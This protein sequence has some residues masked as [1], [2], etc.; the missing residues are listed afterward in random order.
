MPDQQ[1]DEIM[2]IQFSKKDYGEFVTLSTTMNFIRKD[3]EAIK[4]TLE[5]V[6]D[7]QERYDQNLWEFGHE[8]KE[9]RDHLQNIAK[10]QLTSGMGYFLRA[11]WWK[12]GGFIISAATILGAIGEYLYRLPPPK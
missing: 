5:M 6:Q 12:I 7:R 11:N 9:I 4:D 8:V 1:K 10:K 2:T 3:I